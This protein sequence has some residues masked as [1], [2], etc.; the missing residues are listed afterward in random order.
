M[1]NDNEFKFSS[2]EEFD[3]QT[4]NFISEFLELSKDPRN[5][6]ASHIKATIAQFLSNTRLVLREK[7][8]IKKQIT[9]LD[10]IDVQIQE[11]R[12]CVVDL[13]KCK[14]SLNVKG[15]IQ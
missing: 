2:S 1:V 8:E 6:I 3:K 4:H 15:F 14:I 13:E 7:F 10:L 12:R 11:L 9:P 5:E